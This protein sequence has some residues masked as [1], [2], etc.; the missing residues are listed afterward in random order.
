MTGVQTCALPIFI[1]FIDANGNQAWDAGEDTLLGRERVAALAQQQSQS[2]TFRIRNKELPFCDAP[3]YVM[4]DSGLE[5]IE[6]IE[7]NNTLRVGVTC[8]GGGSVQDVGVCIDT[9]GSVS[10]LYN[11]EMEGV[12]KAVENPN[13]IPHDGS[14]RFMLGTDQEMYYGNGIPLHKAQIITP[15]VLPQLI[16]DLK[17]KHNYG[18]YSSGSVKDDNVQDQLDEFTAQQSQEFYA[19]KTRLA[20]LE[21]AAREPAKIG[22]ASC[23]ER[24]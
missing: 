13:I 20:E 24:V 11:L 9:S 3:I 5:V 23:R 8:A 1:A 14:I 2:V 15:A 16:K 18:G 22:R 10:H 17:D 19:M 7:G 4:A 12:I 21:K 6:N